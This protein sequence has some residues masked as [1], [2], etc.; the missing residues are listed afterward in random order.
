VAAIRELC[1]F[2]KA[3]GIAGRKVDATEI[4][5]QMIQNGKSAEDFEKAVIRSSLPEIREITQSPEIGMSQRDL[6]QYSLLKAINGVMGSVN[7]RP[8]TG[9][10]R[11]A[12]EETAKR[13]GRQSSG[14]SF[15]VPHDVMSAEY[16]GGRP[17]RERVMQAGVFTGAGALVPIGAQG[18][19][20]IDLYR[21]KMHVVAMGARVLTGLQ[22]TLAIPRQTG[23]A[24]VA[25]LSETATITASDQTVGQL[26]LTP[27][28]VAAATA[29]TTQLLSQSSPDIE[30]FIREDLMTVLAVEKDRVCLLGT[31]T[32]GEPLGIYNTSG[33]GSTV[34]IT[35]TD[36]LTYAEVVQFETN[37]AAGNADMGALG[38]ITSVYV[39]GKGRVTSRFANTDTPLW[40]QNNIYG[41]YPARATNQLTATPSVIFGNWNDLIIGDW[42]AN[43]IIVDPYSLSMQQQVRIVVHQ[44]TDCGIRHPKSFC[45]GVV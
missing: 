8:F 1:S 12:S 7:G 3:N 35:A 20:L 44:L 40:D 37:V 18:Q 22:G 30:S 2:F 13:H 10:E 36:S 15:F 23:G 19:S 17:S 6:S 21:N 45:F 24:T 14:L 31:G 27:H 34:D 11:E 26:T 9:L 42:A 25:W 5:E 29:F 43:E 32:N 41:I 38:F 33:I 16:S 28:R 4:A 39:R